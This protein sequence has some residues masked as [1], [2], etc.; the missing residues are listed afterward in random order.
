MKENQIMNN[1]KKVNFSERGRSKNAV[2]SFFSVKG[3]GLLAGIVAVMLVVGMIMGYASAKSKTDSNKDPELSNIELLGKYVFF[4]KISSPSRMACVTCHDPATGGTGGVS[5]VNLHQVAI[6]GANP[7][8]VGNLKPPTNAYASLI[9]P[10][11]RPC[12]FGVPGICG[13]NF[14]NGRAEG[15]AVALFPAGATKHIGEEIF[16]DTGGT[17]FTN[18]EILGYSIYFGPTA[19][20]ALNPMPNPVEQN[21]D[22]Q[23]V[24]NHVAN[25]KY[26]KLYKDVWGVKIDCSSDVVAIKADDV[27][28]EKAFDISFKRIMLAVCAWQASADLNSFS[29]KRDKALAE[30]ADGK[31]PLGGLTDQ[32]NLGHDL[33]YGVTS[34]LNPTGK[35]AGCAG[36]HS[37]NPGTDTGE[38]PKQLYADDGYH[39]I[40]VP[41]N[42]EIPPTF[43]DDG[44]FIDPD[45][46]LAGLT[47]VNG[48][49]SNG[50]CSAPGFRRNCDHRGF[51]KTATLR[52]VDKRPGQGFTKA[53]THNGWFK[54]LESIVHFYN[55]GFIGQSTANSFGIT[56][57]P[58]GIET[59]KDALANNCWPAP[60][61]ANPNQPGSPTFGAV[62]GGGRFGDL[63]LTLDEEAAIVAYLKTLTDTYTPKAPKPYK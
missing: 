62:L 1:S 31:F 2:S 25:A 19:D 14:W 60:A 55:T 13:G 45:L 20:Q 35:S 59:E 18:S 43:K 53:Y 12:P 41:R 17:K 63:G 38:E 8:T 39:N 48:D 46:G 33:F 3:Y 30:E 37:D 51:Q 36:C 56:R 5:G 11:F 27:T 61:F 28:E 23:A 15:N 42:P 47:G 4:D 9:V 52:N 6:T 10:L 34:L 21:I 40:G 50:G 24:C 54:S 26:A 58:D 7:H 29:S 32:E 16:Y 49:N 44:T 57:C 22:R